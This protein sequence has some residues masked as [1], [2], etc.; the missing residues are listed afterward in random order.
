[1]AFFVLF[2]LSITTL[3]SQNIIEKTI[4]SDD[5]SSISINGNDIFNISVTTS[6][7]DEIKITSTLDGAYQNDFQIVLKEEKSTLNLSLELL[8]LEEIP[9]DK[10]NAHKVIAATLHIEIPE[11]LTLNIFSDIGS[12]DLKGNF[13]MLYIEL[14]RGQFNIEGEVKTA[15]VNTLDGNIRVITNS[16][17]IEANSN[18]GEI[19]LDEFSNTISI[20]TLTSIHGDITVAKR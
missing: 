9:D 4:Q 16:A 15:T 20:W 18:H 12:V 3:E 17:T 8:S 11:Q 19:E 6:A 5:I 2:S 10:R 1:M 14:L 13:K 7:T